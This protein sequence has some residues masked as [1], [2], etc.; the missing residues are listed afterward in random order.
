MGQ[1]LW[2]WIRTPPERQGRRS[3]SWFTRVVC[4]AVIGATLMAVSAGPSVKAL[5]N[6]QLTSGGVTNPPTYSNGEFWGGG[7]ELET[8]ST[9]SPSGLL[10]RS[11]GQST[12]PGQDVNPMIGDF[13]Y[14]D[15]I[16][17]VG[18]DGGD[19]GLTLTYDSALAADQHYYSLAPQY[20]GYGW[21]SDLGGSVS[22]TSGTVVLNDENGAQTTFTNTT[23]EDGC[24]PGDYQDLQKYTVYGSYDAYCAAN[25]VDAQLGY[26]PTYGVY[27]M[28]R[29]GG[30]TIDAYDAYGQLADIGTNT[31]SSGQ[32]INF[33]YG[34]SPG[35]ANCPSVATLVDCFVE[36]DGSDTSRHVIADVNSTG[37][38][39]EITDPAGRTYSF[40]YSDGN[41]DLND[42]W[43]PPTVS[44]GGVSATQFAYSTGLGLGTTYSSELTYIT[45]PD[46]NDTTINYTG[47]MV[48]QVLDQYA[49]QTTYGYTL[50][51]CAV[52]TSTDC[53]TGTGTQTTTVTYADGEHDSDEYQYG[54]LIMDTW[55]T[56]SGS[57]NETWSF[58]YA[59]PA[60][61]AQ[62]APAT[63][64]VGLPTG[65]ATATIVTDSVGNV[66]SY[67]DPNGNT[68]NSMYNDT[69]GNDLDELCW[70]APP[71]VTVPS[72]ASCSNPPG[73][74]T[75]YTYDQYGHELSE[76]DPVGNTTRS[77][78]YTNGLLCWSAQPTTT[79]T[80]GPCTNTGTSPNGAPS[81]ATTYIYD[82]QGD[83]TTTSIPAS[84][85]PT[86]TTTAEYNLDD[87]VTYSIPPN[88]QGAGAFGSNP[89]ETSDSYEPDGQ[90][91][92]TTGPLSRTTSYTYDAAGNVLTTADPAG[93]TSNAYDHDNRL[94]WSYRAATAY[95]SNVCTSPPS[96][97][98]TVYSGGYNGNT[99]AP[100]AVTDPDGATTSYTYNDY[101]FPTSAT[102]T[103][104]ATVSG[105]P[106]SNIVTYDSYDDYKDT[107]MSG[108]AGPVSA[109]T[110]TFTPGDTLDLYNPEGQLTSSEDASGNTT[111]YTYG[112]NA[113]PTYPT[114]MTRPLSKVTDYTYDADGRLT[115]TE[116]PG[117]ATVETAY[118][119]D[120]RPCV[121]ANSTASIS[122]TSAPSGTGVTL[123]SYDQANQKTSMTDNN[124]TSSQAIDSY[125]YDADG[126]LLSSTNDNAE[127]TNYSYDDA[128]DPTCVSYPNISGSSCT[129]GSRSGSYVTRAYNSAGQLS[130]TTDWLGNT[131]SYSS[132]NPLS[133][134]QSI[135]YPSSTGESVAYS[136]DAD[137]NVTGISYSGSLISGLSGSDSYTP[138]ANNQVGAST[139]LGSY[140]S[141]SDTYDT[142]GRVYQATNPA[143]SG[144]G[145]QSG[146]DTY[147]YNANDEIHTDTPPGTGVSAITYSY[148][149]ADELTTVTNPNKP[150]ASQDNSYGFTA[151]GQRCLSVVGSSTY[152]GVTCGTVPS[153]ATV[154]GAYG[155]NP[156]GQLCW[157]GT[158][159]STSATCASPPS[160]ATSYAYDGDGLRVS[161]KTGA[162]TSDFDWDTVDGD[163]IPLD[164]NDG[165]NS[166]VYGPLLFGGT[167]PIEQISSTGVSFLASTASG[168]QAVF[169][170]TTKTSPTSSADKFTYGSVSAVGSLASAQ[171]TGLTTLSVDPQH[172]GDLMAIA[173]Q[174]PTTTRT[175]SSISGGGVTT[176][177]K[178]TGFSG[179]VGSDEEI[180]YGKVSSTGSSTITVTWSGSV[181]SEATEYSAQEFS[182]GFGSGTTW[183]VDK[184]G[185]L[186]NASSNTLTY[187]SLSPTGAGEL[188]FGYVGVPNT[189]SAGSTSGFTYD[190]TAQGNQVTYSI[191]VSSPS[192]YQPT[193]SQSPAGISSSLGT[194]FTASGSGGGGA[195][196]ISAV[197][198]LAEAS[199]NG[200]TTL[201]VDP[202]HVGDAFVL[203]TMA[204]S[205]G[206]SVSSVSGGGATWSKL[207]SAVDSSN[208]AEEELWLGTIT[209]TGTST[210]TVT[211]SSG[212][213]G[214]ASSLD[215]QEFS[216]S[217]GSSTSWTKD[218]AG[219]SAD[220]T[221]STT[222]AFPSLTPTGSA[223]LY[224][225]YA[226]V[227]N[228]ASAGSTSGFTYDLDGYSNPFIF[229]PSVSSAVAPSAAQSPAGTS[230][231]LGALITATGSGGSCTTGTASGTGPIVNSVSSCSGM[232]GTSVTIT[233]S[234]FSGVTGVSFGST[235]ATSYTVTSTTSI[236][237]V[238]PANS[239]GSYDVTVTTTSGPTLQ[240]L[241]A[242]SVWGV[243]TIQAGTDVT[244]FG[245]QGSYTDPSGLIYLIDRY[246]D[247]STD[248]FLSVDPDLAETGQ[249]Y[250]Y[251]ADDPLNRTDP[252]G[253]DWSDVVSAFIAALASLHFSVGVPHEARNS[254][255]EE[256]PKIAEPKKSPSKTQQ[257]RDPDNQKLP[258][259]PR[260]T[261]N[262]SNSKSNNGSSGRNSSNNSDPSDPNYNFNSD[263]GS[264]GDP[265]T[266]GG[267]DGGGGSLLWGIFPG[268]G[269]VCQMMKILGRPCG[270]PTSG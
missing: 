43:S 207:T 188:Y 195:G 268:A 63:E 129:P 243:Q 176:W 191:D 31:T 162:S 264:S 44:G 214:T 64:T 182:S 138:N 107:C 26:F 163:K 165:T 140:S 111:T 229:N 246:Y 270:G 185:T 110:C 125:T 234:N 231:A 247:P 148:D 73:G 134:V 13:T 249:P 232:A 93:V 57:D 67:T 183:A 122:C 1:A 224:A 45:D 95:G 7:S 251:T 136:Y 113:F 156:Y 22:V 190:A 144:T 41:T 149:A 137:G 151:D 90:V 34:V 33:T 230:E 5:T 127:T 250:A 154:V 126:N 48:S 78:Y 58:N 245:F 24:P 160:G 72:N 255:P 203:S 199:G 77:G 16:I 147:A 226:N 14:S 256:K 112:D 59:N 171:G 167:A 208:G 211:Y 97:G 3:P 173:I 27:Q 42:I 180:W 100:N 91:A 197:G 88:G 84:P 109:G 4:L 158:S 81:G 124:G 212:I 152:S 51:D 178:A 128:D 143:T 75:T 210:I 266:G 123:Y 23:S 225:G 9:C 11:G 200:T 29:W 252:N 135:A 17:S 65:S 133:E 221:S 146:P 94:C 145:S 55:G 119:A 141:S 121:V 222:V 130:S 260:S 69:G 105:N 261:G 220:T 235:P 198:S 238:A 71:G 153:G 10:G 267:G 87:Q 164:T 170:S 30:Q 76:T 228:S 38:V 218:V 82:A 179:S 132:Y 175:V 166:Y 168:V 244:P 70:T 50:S 181:S 21:N 120:S 12:D 2:T 49:A 68:T 40:G 36:T 241:A 265:T 74:S 184:T 25:R 19:L 96:S 118:D 213:S 66:V 101:R 206:V 161:S 47:G 263:G 174:I 80:G 242:Y 85:S 227:A 192:A 169:G 248:Q 186:N 217:T 201:S 52:P 257:P 102:V 240:E 193:A 53:V 253:D 237:A 216:S 159:T 89:Y 54:Q 39:F 269:Q 202:Q 28:N 116:D 142:Y 259:E 131:V 98:A 177:T 150:S 104:E 209:T 254:L 215:A 92:S 262:S 103:T 35:S 219:T 32:D 187:P 236:T 62:D 196:T 233:G 37:R 108:P 189:P 79:A 204:V 83:A 139:S 56:S 223:E 8:C 46:S 117:S 20:F 115:A 86:K 15:P 258:E 99:D 61:S 155:W 205:T 6:I 106:Q 114:V 60:P 18:A 239:I 157:S 172:A 194:V